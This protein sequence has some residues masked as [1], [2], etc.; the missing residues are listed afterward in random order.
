MEREDSA[1][2][3]LVSPEIVCE[4]SKLIRSENNIPTELIRFFL[5]AFFI[6]YD[7][8]KKEL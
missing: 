1:Q 5:L 3:Y 8:Q 2:L 7:L 6:L 4:T